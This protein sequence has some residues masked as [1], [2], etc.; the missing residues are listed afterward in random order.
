MEDG[1]HDLV[2]KKHYIINS[3]GTVHLV[4]S[5]LPQKVLRVVSAF[6]WKADKHLGFALLKLALESRRIRSPTASLM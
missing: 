1:Y 4:L 6:G 2:K 5:S 3:I